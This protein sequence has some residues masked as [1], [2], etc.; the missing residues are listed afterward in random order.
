[1][2][3]S[4]VMDGSNPDAKRRA[5]IGKARLRYDDREKGEEERGR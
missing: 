1:M 3:V 4:A 2:T 5:I